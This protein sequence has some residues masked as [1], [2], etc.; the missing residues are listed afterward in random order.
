MSRSDPYD[1]L[2][3]VDQIPQLTRIFEELNPGRDHSEIEWLSVI[4]EQ[5]I[6]LNLIALAKAYPQYKWFKVREDTLAEQIR[7]TEA[8]AQDMRDRIERGGLVGE[9]YGAP[10]QPLGKGMQKWMKNEHGETITFE[11]HAEAHKGRRPKTII[12]SGHGSI[13]GDGSIELTNQEI[14]KVISLLNE[15]KIS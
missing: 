4:S 15:L 6:H 9:V 12:V 2:H 11:A 5:Q 1:W 10:Q 8:K 14:D 7:E 3:P 13:P